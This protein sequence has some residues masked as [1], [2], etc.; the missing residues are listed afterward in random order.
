MMEVDHENRIRDDNRIG[1][2]RAAGQRAN[3]GNMALPRDNTSGR[4]GVTW[5]KSR[6][7]WIVHIGINR[8]LKYLGRYASIDDASDAYDRAAIAH[9]GVD[10]ALTNARMVNA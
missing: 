8:R 3:L 5:D 2:L 9:F 10:F 4:K 1:N 7:L 6:G